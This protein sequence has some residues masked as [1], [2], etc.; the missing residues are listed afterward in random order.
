M[1]AASAAYQIAYNM[2]EQFAIQQGY[3][4]SPH[5]LYGDF[6]KYQWMTSEWLNDDFKRYIEGWEK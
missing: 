5:P 3:R 6:E 2:S 1:A 4:W